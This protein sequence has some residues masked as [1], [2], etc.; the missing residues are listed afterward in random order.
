MTLAQLWSFLT[1]I[2]SP[3]N[4]FESWKSTLYS[5]VDYL[6]KIESSP[7]SENIDIRKMFI[8]ETNV[9]VAVFDMLSL[10]VIWHT[11][12]LDDMFGY[13]KEEFKEKGMLLFFKGLT[14]SHKLFLFQSVILSNLVFKTASKEQRLEYLGA[15][16][17]G[18]RATN[19]KTGL[20]FSYSLRQHC[21]KADDNGNPLHYLC[22]MENC[23]H[24][25][26]NDRFWG[27]FQVGKQDKMIHH[28][29]SNQFLT[30]KGDI[31][32]PREIEILELL[33]K[34]LESIEIGNRLF[35]SPHTVDKHRKNMISKT[36]ARNITALLEI[37]KTCQII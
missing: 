10:N 36:G 5:Q 28:F 7:F 19:P 31:L 27:R 3:E 12:N 23:T 22:L 33:G 6:S 34:G 14:F 9:F 21:I 1:K 20:E 11:D 4:L 2:K 18:L 24:L 26:K 8:N 13:T 35:I 30:M 25:V 37:A 15:Q 17:V 29:Y 16:Y 32:T